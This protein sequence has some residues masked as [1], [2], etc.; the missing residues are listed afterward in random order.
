MRDDSRRTREGHARARR[1]DRIAGPTAIASLDPASDRPRAFARTIA[2]MKRRAL[3]LL[4]IVLATLTA[5]A[6]EKPDAVPEAAPEAAA[7]AE[8]DLWAGVPPLT[9]HPADI[10]G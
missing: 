8:L 5:C 3:A 4:P 2:T 9:P 6:D 10:A 1:C 7:P